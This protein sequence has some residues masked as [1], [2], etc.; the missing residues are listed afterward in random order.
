MA[1]A[2]LILSHSPSILCSSCSCHALLARVNSSMLIAQNTS[3]ARCI[4]PMA[5]P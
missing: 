1:A 2:T 3:G 4:Q 5:T